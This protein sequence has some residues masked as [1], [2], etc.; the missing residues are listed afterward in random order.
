MAGSVLL[1]RRPGLAPLGSFELTAIEGGTQLRFSESAIGR[2][3]AASMQEKDKGWRFLFEGCL[4]AHLE[5]TAPPT[6]GDTSQAC[7]QDEAR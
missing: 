7:S 3:D 4:R 1:R 5:G 6:W 2:I